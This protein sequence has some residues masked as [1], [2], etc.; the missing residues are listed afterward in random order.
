[1]TVLL[2]AGIQ[3]GTPEGFAAGC[4]REKDCPALAEH[5][6]CC[7]FAHLRSTTDRR[8]HLAKQRDPSPAAIARRLG[9][10]P[11][12]STDVD[13]ESAVDEAFASRADDY[14][15]RPR[16]GAAK[17]KQS[18]TTPTR[19]ET[20]VPTPADVAKTSKPLTIEPV[21]EIS[22]DDVTEA[23]ATPTAPKKKRTGHKPAP[24][25]SAGLTKAERAEC[26][27]WA[28]ANGHEL[29][30]AGRIPRAIVD[31]WL[32]ARD[33]TPIAADGTSE[34][35]NATSAVTIAASED[36]I[37]PESDTT[38]VDELPID[39]PDL[40]IDALAA[41]I[42]ELPEEMREELCL[43]CL[44][45]GPVNF[46]CEHS[47][48]HTPMETS[49]HDANGEPW[50]EEELA[51]E[52]L[53][54]V[55]WA[56]GE[57]MTATELDEALAA[58]RQRAEL[59]QLNR[60]ADNEPDLDD[61]HTVPASIEAYANPAGPRPE[62]ADVTIPEDIEKARSIAVRLEQELAHVEEQLRTAHNAVDVT[63]AKWDTDTSA[64]KA[65]IARLTIDCAA[66]RQTANIW[67]GLY[68]SAQEELMAYRLHHEEETAAA[69]AAT[70][71]TAAI[72]GPTILPADPAPVPARR[73]FWKRGR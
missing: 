27:A 38:D 12:S 48:A 23:P 53:T 66:A 16:R 70:Y 19:K 58:A 11:P 43:V 46:E 4:R 55:D 35:A 10:Q 9:I 67:A 71:G 68:R 17:P 29:G 21:P 39:D 20:P 45:T 6:M 57:K 73:S 37:E 41:E 47:D 51:E 18:T 7:L 40:D 25:A 54:L 36:T 64:L 62:W 50:A 69:W 24:S 72:Y 32:A 61:W 59:E 22:D 3:H 63:L 28:A 56:P 14:R 5:G 33:E 49:K 44:K 52:D 8:Y 42:A 1:M 31:A 65:E 13:K 15:F 30:T 2:P 26:R 60:D 34:A